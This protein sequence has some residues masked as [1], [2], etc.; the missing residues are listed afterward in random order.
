MRAE[1]IKDEKSQ[2]CPIVGHLTDFLVAV[3]GG[4]DVIPPMD[5]GLI[6]CQ[7]SRL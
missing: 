5:R 6:F 7:E 2:K 4:A 1:Q 3:L